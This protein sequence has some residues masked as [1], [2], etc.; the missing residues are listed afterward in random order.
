MAGAERRG[1]GSRRVAT[2]A[3]LAAMAA[4]GC[5]EEAP[6]SGAARQAA[7]PGQG[8]DGRYAGM[9][10]STGAAGFGR[11]HDCDPPRR[12]LVEVRG[13][14]FSLETP[15]RN[16]ITAAPG[17]TE[18]GVPVYEAVIA[19]DGSIEGRSPETNGTLTGRAEAGRIG[20]EVFGLLCTYRFSAE[21][22]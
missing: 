11:P 10:E 16:P 5:A 9:L 13:G 8:F 6:P 7:A 21:R 2:L 3:V 22:T 20:G 14:R 4:A 17:R 19:A 12:L 15:A 18:G 1:R